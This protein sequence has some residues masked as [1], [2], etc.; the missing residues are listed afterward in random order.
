MENTEPFFTA[1][2]GPCLYVS[3]GHSTQRKNLLLNFVPPA[4]LGTSFQVSPQYHQIVAFL[5]LVRKLNSTSERNAVS[6]RPNLRVKFTLLLVINDNVNS[7][8]C[9]KATVLGV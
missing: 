6:L 4:P 3:C 8:Y 1:L 2:S 5:V 7:P 9:L